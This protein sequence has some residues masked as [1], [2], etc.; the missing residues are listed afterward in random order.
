MANPPLAPILLKKTWLFQA[1]VAGP[2][3]VILGLCAMIA[4]WDGGYWTI[5][6]FVTDT[7]TS[8]MAAGII[9]IVLVQRQ[10]GEPDADE[11]KKW[12]LRFE[13]AK[14]GLATG[15]WV[16]LMADSIWGPGISY[17]ERRIACSAI[18]SVL[19]FL[20]FYP[21][22]VYAVYIQGGNRSRQVE[23]GGD[24]AERGERTPLLQDV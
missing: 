2:T 23:R 15:L 19:L 21:T 3:F 4:L 17:R 10:L 20:F 1:I 14:S 11:M 18:A 9:F 13:V 16:W 5:Y 6:D 8:I 22:A 24:E 7:C 12:T